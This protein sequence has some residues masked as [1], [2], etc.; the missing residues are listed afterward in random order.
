MAVVGVAAGGGVRRDVIGQV[1]PEGR[2]WAKNLL[3]AA[4]K[5]ADYAASL[6]LDLVPGVVL[7]QCPARQ[8]L[9]A[10]YRGVTA[11]TASGRYRGRRARQPPRPQG[12]RPK[13][14]SEAAA[15][16]RRVSRLNLSRSDSV[17]PG[18]SSPSRWCAPALKPLTPGRQARRAEGAP[19][20]R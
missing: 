19:L 4:G 14:A 1:T 20:T 10:R 7:H 15:P 6:G 3:W 5:L 17:T 9:Q 13:D 2:E 16:R 12:F 8:R 11:G 18:R